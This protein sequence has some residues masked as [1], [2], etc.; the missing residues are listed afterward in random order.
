MRTCYGL[1]EYTVGNGYPSQEWHFIMARGRKSKICGQK[2]LGADPPLA[3]NIKPTTRF[4]SRLG[5]NLSL[6]P[7]NLLGS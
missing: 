4:F 6:V 2:M 3:I 5:A 1:N 7:S